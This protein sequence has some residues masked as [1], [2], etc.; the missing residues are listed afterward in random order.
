MHAAR[1]VLLVGNDRVD[2]LQLTAQRFNLVHQRIALVT[3]YA[4]K[5][6]KLTGYELPALVNRQK[7][8]QVL[9]ML[10]HQLGSLLKGRP[11]RF[12]QRPL[13][14]LGSELHAVQGIANFV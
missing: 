13:D 3:H 7:I 10:M 6:D 11:F 14:Q 4:G 2:V 1:T 9:P 8:C 12:I 5:F